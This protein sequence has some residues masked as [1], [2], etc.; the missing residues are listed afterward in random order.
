MI[1]R[2]LKIISVICGLASSFHGTFG[3]RRLCHARDAEASNIDVRHCLVA[4]GCVKWDWVV[5][6][7]CEYCI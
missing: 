7:I 3:G 2:S 4:K 5:L 1:Y 6:I